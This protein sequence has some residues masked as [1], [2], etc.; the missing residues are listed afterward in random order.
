MFWW[1]TCNNHR[2]SL[3]PSHNTPH[4]TKWPADF[5]FG[6]GCWHRP[7]WRRLLIGGGE[8]FSLRPRNVVSCLGVGTVHSRIMLP[9]IL[10]LGTSLNW[11]AEAL[12][13]CLRKWM[14]GVYKKKRHT[15][16]VLTWWSAATSCKMSSSFNLWSS[17]K[18]R[19][20]REVLNC[21]GVGTFD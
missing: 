3:F 6:N 8:G 13:K 12:L 19:A 15:D 1:H 5:F 9:P 16:S 14:T 21:A 4:L 10:S 2:W 20:K 18:R 17:G 7:E 11:G